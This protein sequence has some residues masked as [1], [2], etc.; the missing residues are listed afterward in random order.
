MVQGFV[1]RVL[2]PIVM[3]VLLLLVGTLYALARGLDSRALVVGLAVGM[4][5]LY[6][7]RLYDYI[8]GPEEAA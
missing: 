1:V 3:Q 2:V 7:G 5:V 4:G 6:A 8:L